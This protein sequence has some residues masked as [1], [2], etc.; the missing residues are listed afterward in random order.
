MTDTIMIKGEREDLHRLIRQREKVMKSAAKHR[1]AELLDDFEN[2]MGQQFSFDQDEVWKQ[3]TKVAEREVEKAQRLLAARCRELGIPEHFAPSLDLHWFSRGENAVKGRRQ[4]LRKMAETRIEA[5]ERKAI[6][7]IELSCLQA[8]ERIAIAGLSSDAAKLFIKQLP[9]IQT[10]MPRLSFTEIAGDSE[11]PAAEQLISPNALR[12]R[13]FRE[14]QKQ[15]K[16]EATNVTPFARVTPYEHYGNAGET[17][18]K[19]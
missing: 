16:A 4:E 9:D 11:P 7:D 10:L 3:A 6:T 5:I 13:R 8:Q 17:P 1:S 15:L 14:R 19:E 12:Q 2:Q 18:E